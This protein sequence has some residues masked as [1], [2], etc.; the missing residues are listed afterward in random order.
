[1][2]SLFRPPAARYTI[3]VLDRALF[4]KTVNLAAVSIADKKKI[5]QWRQSLQQEKTLLSAERL[6]CVIAHPDQTLASQGTR[7]LLLDPKVRPRGK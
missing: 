2:S 7:C 5:A 3:G 4:A 1:M 6:P